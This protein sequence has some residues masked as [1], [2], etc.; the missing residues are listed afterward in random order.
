VLNESELIPNVSCER[1][2]GPGSAHVAATRA[3]SKGPLVPFGN[4]RWT[5]ESLMAL[6]GQC[7]RHPSE[8]LPG[9][10]RPEVTELARF[11]PVG[12]MQSRCYKESDG[13]FSCVTCHEPHARAS[14]DRAG[15]EA[16]CLSCHGSAPRTT[17][18]VSPRRGCL[19]CHMPKVD[20]GQ[21]VLFTDHWI[22][23]RKPG[24]G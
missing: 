18:P 22:R 19:D 1:C 2:H 3:G 14:T 10:I 12:I 24:G 23:V 17:C 16:S 4:G 9:R 11:Q 13:A 21:R 8:A 15:Y 20:A 7:H 5:A 6:C